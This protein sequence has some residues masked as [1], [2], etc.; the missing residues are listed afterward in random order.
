MPNDLIER[1]LAEAKVRR[2]APDCYDEGITALFEEAATA[3]SGPESMRQ[4]AAK[5]VEGA[6]AG[7]EL[8]RFYFDGKLATNAH[9]E[10]LFLSTK[11]ASRL[12]AERAAQIR[13]LPVPAQAGEWK[14]IESAPKGRKLIVGYRNVLGKWRAII[15]AYYLP[16]TLDASEWNDGGDEHGFAPEGWYEESET[17]DELL[18]CETPTHW[19]PLPAAPVSLK[20]E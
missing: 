18:P 17:H 20:G 14:P 9:G 10:T 5:I 15:A 11:E 13:A 16:G 6:V 2:A 8:E 4:A 7:V 12:L 3:L 1:L 19:M